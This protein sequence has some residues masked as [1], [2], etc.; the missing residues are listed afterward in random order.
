LKKIFFPLISLYGRYGIL[1]NL[2]I[3]N[4][5]IRFK[6]TYLGLLWAALEPLLYFIVLYVV[7]TTIRIRSHEDFAIYLITGILLY[8]IFARGAS[9]GL[10]SLTSSAGILRSLKIPHELFPVTATLAIGILGLVDVA[11]F[12]GLMPIFQFVPT[13]TIVLLPLVLALTLLL[14]LGISYFLSILNVYARDTQHIWTIFVHALMFM[15]PIFWYVEDIEEGILLSIHKINP[16]GQLVEIAHSLVMWNEI[17]SI[18]TWLYA[19]FLV[20]II[21]IP[22]FILFTLLKQ[23]VSEEL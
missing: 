2:A 12:F 1:F 14:I 17:P 16:L 3:L 20:L 6:N 8:H 13:T 15:T 11:V 23:K 4:I 10:S 5:K 19:T 22:G 18:E 7:F 21:F 9:G